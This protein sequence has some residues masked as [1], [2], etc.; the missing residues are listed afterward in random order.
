M[1]GIE[2]ASLELLRS[3]SHCVY[4]SNI[5]LDR[6]AA[7]ANSTLGSNIGSELFPCSIGVF[8][9]KIAKRA[10]RELQDS[11]EMES[12]DIAMNVPDFA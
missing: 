3:A 4:V 10:N 7:F 11:L 12:V 1:C 5:C 2:D 6:D 9:P 8:R